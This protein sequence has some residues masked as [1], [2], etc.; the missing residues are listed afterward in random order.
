MDLFGFIN[1]DK[2]DKALRELEA[3][4]KAYESM[5][6]VGNEAVAKLYMVR[7]AAML[8]IEKMEDIL[9]RQPDFDI[10][11]IK[12]IADARAS[13]RL[14]TE[15]VQNEVRS[16]QNNEN[17]IDDYSEVIAM[18]TTFATAALTAALRVL[19]GLATTARSTAGVVGSNVVLGIGS[20]LLSM[21]GPIGLAIGGVFAGST[22]KKNQQIIEEAT[23]M[24][25]DLDRNTKKI[26]KTI[27]KIIQL[28][29][30][31]SSSV[32]KLS[33][34]STLPPD[35]LR[36]K[37]NEIVAEIVNLCQKINRKFTV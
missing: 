12:K 23:K 11:S 1:S 22:L 20:T 17:S 33:V 2:K 34:L 26:R 27:G 21:A 31:I 4:Q 14:F 30:E 16:E 7:K 19:P 35:M 8:E 15:A 36:P 5:G 13:I 3:S 18:S 28:S 32:A 6:K 10:Q 9:K 25:S 29:N 37:Y 24:K